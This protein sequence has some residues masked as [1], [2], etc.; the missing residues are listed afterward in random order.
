[1]GGKNTAVFAMY[2][3]RSAV[4]EAIQHLRHGGFRA[5]DVSVMIPENVGTKDFGHEKGTK[6]AEGAIVGTV[7]GGLIGGVL[8]WLITVGII[9]IPSLTQLT[10]GGPIVAA[11][12]GMGALGALGALIGALV[13]LGVPEYE[14]VR[15]QG[16]IRDGGV[17]MSVHCDNSDWVNRAKE[18]L[19]HTGGLDVGVASEKHGDFAVTDKPQPRVLGSRDGAAGGVAIETLPEDEPVVTRRVLVSKTDDDVA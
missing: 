1:M 4:E 19:R 6:A 13:G 16:R 9:A 8:A 12:A 7:A 5:T 14:A 2:P 11:L 17:L 15:Y 10:A 18:G 3:S